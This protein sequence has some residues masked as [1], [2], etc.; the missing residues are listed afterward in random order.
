MESD[1][2]CGVPSSFCAT[3][4]LQVRHARQE[5]VS[6]LLQ[7]LRERRE[8]ASS[9]VAGR[10]VGVRESVSVAAGKGLAPPPWSHLELLGLELHH[11][12]KLVSFSFGHVH[13]VLSWSLT[14]R[15]SRSHLSQ[16]GTLYDLRTLTNT[17]L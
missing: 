4:L 17:T 5:L 9:E 8:V 3:Y 2:G 10:G 11:R 7:L 13:K 1:S 15:S 6:R 14:L 16:R 12:V